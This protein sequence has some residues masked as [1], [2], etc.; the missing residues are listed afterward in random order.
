MVRTADLSF[1]E[2]LQL[3]LEYIEHYTLGRDLAIL[4]RTVP[5]L[6]QARGAR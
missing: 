1:A 3:E 4:L 6:F 2:R 5:V